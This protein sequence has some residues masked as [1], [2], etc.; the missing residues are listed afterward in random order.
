MSTPHTKYTV[1]QIIGAKSPNLPDNGRSA[2]NCGGHHQGYEVAMRLSRHSVPL[3]ALRNYREG[4]GETLTEFWS[5]FGV[6]KSAGANY[7][8]GAPMAPSLVLFLVLEANGFISPEALQLAH[9]Q[10]DRAREGHALDLL[11]KTA[12]AAGSGL[13]GATDVAAGDLSGTRIPRSRCLTR[14]ARRVSLDSLSCRSTRREGY[15]TAWFR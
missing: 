14:T 11:H 3:F 10:L 12:P 6:S 4:R 7:E 1:T 2:R 5:R 9:G 8:A 13:G 15:R